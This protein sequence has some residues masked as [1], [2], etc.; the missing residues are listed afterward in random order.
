[1]LGQF[2]TF[3]L[4]IVTLFESET[5]ADDVWTP[6]VLHSDKRQ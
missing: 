1:M 3:I 6:N 5:S 4:A 2:Q